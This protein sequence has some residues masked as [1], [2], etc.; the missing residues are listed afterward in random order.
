MNYACTFMLLNIENL[1]PKSNR[2]ELHLS[3]IDNQ[4]LAR[5]ECGS[6]LSLKLTIHVE[7]KYDK[8][9]NELISCQ[10]RQSD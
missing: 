10:T 9:N 7:I 5:I 8:G 6:L 4:N 1:K 2:I 3:T